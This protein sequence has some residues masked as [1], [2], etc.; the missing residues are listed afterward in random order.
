MRFDW[1][2]QALPFN[3]SQLSAQATQRYAT[4]RYATQRYATQRNATQRNATQRYAAT[5]Q[6]RALPGHVP[7]IV[8]S[9]TVGR[10]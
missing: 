6:T 3:F 7:C 5:I 10:Y 9:Q 2:T 8:A 1:L 4:Q